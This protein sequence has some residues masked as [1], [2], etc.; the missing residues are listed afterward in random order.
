MQEQ[1]MMTG[2]IMDDPVVAL[3]KGA[4]RLKNEAALNKFP[5]EFAGEGF[6]YQG[7]TSTVVV[8]V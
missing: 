1:P 3:L 6:A 2:P 4:E 8:S 5:T 7:S